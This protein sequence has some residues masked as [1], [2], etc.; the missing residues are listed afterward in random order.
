V[1]QGLKDRICEDILAFLEFCYEMSH[2][3]SL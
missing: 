1:A 3:M 2:K